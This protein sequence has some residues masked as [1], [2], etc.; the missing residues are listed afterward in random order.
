MALRRTGGGYKLACVAV[1]QVTFGS[2][3]KRP[4][5]GSTLAGGQLARATA[6][7]LIRPTDRGRPR[8]SG[9]LIVVAALVWALV[10]VGAHGGLLSAERHAVHAV[11]AVHAGHPL[12]ASWGAEFA[13]S[14]HHAHMVDG[15][16]HSHHPEQFATA[17]LPRSAT[18][19]AA[20]AV[21]VTVVAA[22]VILDCFVP[23]G[24]GPPPALAPVVTG[25]DLLTRFCLARR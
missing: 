8:W 14:A 2:P 6:F 18:T 15:S 7:A 25:Q 20:L 9:P 10:G 13:V 4:A 3:A 12:L 23:G 22:L 21:V 24:R 17:V 11:H 16:A 5:G 19:L 1:P